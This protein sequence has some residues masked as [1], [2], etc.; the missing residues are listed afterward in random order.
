MHEVD[1][2]PSNAGDSKV[3]QVNPLVIIAI[4]INAQTWDLIVRY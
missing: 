2:A 1:R 4:E 3:A